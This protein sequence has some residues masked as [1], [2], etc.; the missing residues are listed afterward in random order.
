M[1]YS[2]L[3]WTGS[4]A[5]HSSRAPDTRERLAITVA[6]IYGR[7]SKRFFLVITWLY[8][9]CEACRLLR[10][11]KGS[12]S[13]PFHR[14]YLLATSRSFTMH[15]IG[16]SAD[17]GDVGPEGP[18]RPGGMSPTRT[19]HDSASTRISSRTHSTH[20]HLTHLTC[21]ELVT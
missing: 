18:L 2:L 7:F 3:A 21:L 16:V 20:V 4:H 5:G 9:L 10:T 6:G 8:T 15:P 12:V 11:P 14:L 13:Q 17:A 1:F 19:S